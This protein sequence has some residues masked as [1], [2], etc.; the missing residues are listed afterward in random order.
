MCCNFCEHWYCLTCSKLKRVVYQ[1]LKESPDSL[2]WFCIPCLTSF[3]GVKKM[4]VK[5]T[6]LEEKYD[7]LDERVSKIE[8]QPNNVENIEDI[9]RQEVRELKDIETRKMNMVCFNLPE[10]LSQDADVR[11]MEDAENLKTVVDDDM[12]L[13]EKQI[14]LDNLI[15]LGK[16]PIDS[17]ESQTRH[18]PL[19][20]KVKTFESKREILQANSVLKD[21]EDEEKRKIFNTP[22]LT[23]KQREKSFKLREELRYRKNVLSETNLK[24]SRGR[25]VSSTNDRDS[26]RPSEDGLREFRDRTFV[27]RNLA[28]GRGGPPRGERPP[29]HEK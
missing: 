2:M 26:T 23:Q 22:D 25:I 27:N 28:G 11:Q 13:G 5:V 24:I 29:F 16:R 1:A 18:R 9:V 6:S 20:F 14:Q 8:E 12:K 21:H 17:D 15:R 7:K 10:S 19:R 3:S 4:M